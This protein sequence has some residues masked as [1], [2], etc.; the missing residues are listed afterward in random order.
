MRQARKRE[1]LNFIGSLYQAHEEIREAVEKQDIASV[2]AMLAECQE[3]AVELGNAI[4]KTE[5]EGCVTVSHVEKYCETIFR[6]FEEIS[7]QKTGDTSANSNISHNPNKIYKILKKQLLKVENSVKND[8]AVRKEVVFFP[9]KASMWDSLESVY[10]AAKADSDC[11]AYCVPIPYFDLNADHSFGTM[12]YEGNEYPPNI[13]IVDWQ[14][15]N[16]EE[17]RPDIIFIHNP[18]D[19][20]NHVTSVHPRFYAKNLKEYTTQLVYIPYFILGDIKKDDPDR[21]SKIDGMKHFCFTPGIIY[22]DKVIVQS[23]DMRQIYIE[24]Y[25]KEAKS[26]NLQVTRQGLEEKILGL[27]SPKIDKVMNT[28]KEQIDIPETWLE[29]LRKSDGSLKKVILYNTCITAMLAYEA[30][31]IDKLSYTLNF[32]RENKDEVVLLWRPHP[33]LE[34]SIRTMRP[35]VLDKYLEL[36]NRYISEEWGIYDDTADLN[37]AMLLSDA[38]YGDRSSVVQLYQQMGKPIMI[39]N[40][41]IRN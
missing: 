16:F 12:H 14:S 33:L 4:E 34:N 22:A 20:W 35:R 6:V 24:E 1:I 30:E 9:Y 25:L 2:Q 29:I 11:D 26:I 13:E 7:L 3:F 19:G 21:Q 38:Y 28:E 5:G 32:F 23:E 17:R 40:I 10:L 31:W 27:G 41:N 39:Q 18:Y 36:K 37:R 15:Y 8:I